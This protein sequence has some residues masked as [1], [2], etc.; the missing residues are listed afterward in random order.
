MFTSRF[1]RDPNEVTHYVTDEVASRDNPQ[2]KAVMTDPGSETGSRTKETRKYL[3]FGE[4]RFGTLYDTFENYG[5]MP[6]MSEWERG[7]PYRRCA[8]E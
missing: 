4:L 8:G 2:A 6:K 3:Q 1:T 5:L 7:E